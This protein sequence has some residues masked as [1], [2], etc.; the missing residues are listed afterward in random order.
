MRGLV[1][2]LQK[3][4]KKGSKLKTLLQFAWSFR[5]CYKNHSEKQSKLKRLIQFSWSGKF[6]Q[7]PFKKGSG[8]GCQTAVQ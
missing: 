1:E 8:R 4:F 5:I 2:F 3:P 6:L 7:K